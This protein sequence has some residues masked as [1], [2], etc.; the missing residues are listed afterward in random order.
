MEKK[1]VGLGSCLEEG[2][3]IMRYRNPFDTAK[4]KNERRHLWYYEH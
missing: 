1:V 4:K 3:K 2:N